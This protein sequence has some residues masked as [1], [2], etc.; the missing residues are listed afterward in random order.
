M[1]PSFGESGFYICEGDVMAKTVSDLDM[2]L[3]WSRTGTDLKVR[4]VEGTLLF[5]SSVGFV[6]PLLSER[7][8]KWVTEDYNRK[9]KN[10]VFA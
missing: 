10:Y 8:V 6:S 3:E 4:T 7:Q 2:I 5:S 9:K 1:P